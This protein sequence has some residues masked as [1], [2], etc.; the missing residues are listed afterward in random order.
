LAVFADAAIYARRLKAQ[1]SADSRLQ[2]IET[3][4]FI[5]LNQAGGFIQTEH[6]VH[7][8]DR[9]AEAPLP[10]LSKRAAT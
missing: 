7:A 3:C 9:R 1:G 4:L 10:R 8:L 6:D 5:L 2:S